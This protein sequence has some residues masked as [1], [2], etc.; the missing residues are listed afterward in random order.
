MLVV[1]YRKRRSPE[2]LSSLLLIAALF[3]TGPL[4]ATMEMTARHGGVG[5]GFAAAVCL[6]ALCEL[7]AV[8]RE[9]GLRFSP[10]GQ[11]AVGGCV[12][13]VAAAP[14]WLRLTP[15]AAGAN[16]LALYAIW[17]LL[18]G[19]ALLGLGAFSWHARRRREDAPVS[20]GRRALHIEM[21]FVAMVLG[22]SA[23]HLW[24]MN[25]AFL[26]HARLFY[27]SPVLVA[28]SVILFE[29]LARGGARSWILWVT[30]AV[31]AALAVGLSFEGF[32]EDVATG[33]LPAALQDPLL[34]M[35]VLAAGASWY[36]CVRGGPAVLI[37]MGALALLVATFRFTDM[38]ASL[39]TSVDVARPSV[40]ISREE[41]AIVAYAVVAYLMLVAWLRRSRTEV[42]LALAA[43]WC[44][45]ALLI[46]GRTSAGTMSVTLLAGWSGLA[47]MHVALACP[48]WCLRIWPILFLVV[49]TSAFGLREDVGLHAAAHAGGMV[50]VL[51]G[52]GMVWP[53]TRYRAVGLTVGGFFAAAFVARG[54]AGTPH[55]KAAIAV[56]SAFALLAAGAVVSWHKRRLL[57]LAGQVPSEDRVP[58]EAGAAGD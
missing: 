5:I 52:V 55:A 49:A 44:A 2:D 54:V 3:W 38:P 11:C 42:L 34:V 48:S 56:L 14:A 22:A 29:Y 10:W 46:G 50:L 36:G 21:V 8:R 12:I 58:G 17:W 19:L 6:I 51:T 40:P 20:D 57:M 7:H 4:A 43:H 15:E 13:L 30:C 18:A 37:H 32:H 26:A 33:A 41:L 16:E 45:F 25:Y 24:A 53:W 35:F 47:G 28:L 39:P 9:L 23:A 31:P 1:L 27:A